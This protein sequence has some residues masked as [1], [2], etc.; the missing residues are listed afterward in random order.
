MG[1]ERGRKGEKRKDCRT[2]FF[3]QN[4]LQFENDPLSFLSV[5]GMSFG[6]AERG[7][8]PRSLQILLFKAD[9]IY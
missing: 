2:L 7:V 1:S 3:V 5:V 8:Q 4:H 6:P 9:I